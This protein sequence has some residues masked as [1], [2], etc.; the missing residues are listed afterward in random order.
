MTKEVE[1]MLYL[2]CVLVVMTIVLVFIV[3]KEINGG[4]KKKRGKKYGRTNSK[5]KN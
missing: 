1:L 3:L 5:R 4:S 2:L